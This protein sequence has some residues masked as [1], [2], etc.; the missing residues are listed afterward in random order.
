M[1]H[2][3]CAS[4]RLA[5]LQMAGRFTSSM[6]VNDARM[7]RPGMAPSVLCHDSIGFAFGDQLGSAPCA[8]PMKNWMWVSELWA[9]KNQS[10]ILGW[11]CFDRQ[12]STVI[13]KRHSAY[14]RAMAGRLTNDNNA[15]G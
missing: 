5:S 1:S 2:E 8:E 4:M 10:A 6:L 9:L 11:P 7:M 14:E 3:C 15:Q 13:D 12:S